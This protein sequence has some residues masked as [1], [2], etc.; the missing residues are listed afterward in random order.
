MRVRAQ[1]DEA[2]RQM[3][4]SKKEVRGVGRADLGK[5]RSLKLRAR[6]PAMPHVPQTFDSGTPPS[7]S[8][9]EAAAGA[10]RHVLP[11]RLSR[12]SAPRARLFR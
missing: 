5:A 8:H 12:P 4:W 7:V 2:V 11:E 10:P 1:L 6:L 3:G 9:V